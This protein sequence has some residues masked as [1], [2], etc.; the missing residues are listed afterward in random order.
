MNKIAGS[1]ILTEITAKAADSVGKEGWADAGYWAWAET[2]Y[3]YNFELRISQDSLQKGGTQLFNLTEGAEIG[4]EVQV[5]DNDTGALDC[6]SKW[7]S[8]SN[9]SSSVPALFGTAMLVQVGGISEP[10]AKN[11]EVFVPSVLNGSAFIEYTIPARSTVKVTLYNLAGQK[12]ASLINSTLDAGTHSAELD[13]SDLANGVYL[14]RIS[15]CGTSTSKK[16]LLI[17]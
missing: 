5:V 3:G 15:A 10:I 14:L 1:S 9:N 6:I 2:P 13:V 17:K 8:P 11:V 12:A 4:F 7:W 16:I